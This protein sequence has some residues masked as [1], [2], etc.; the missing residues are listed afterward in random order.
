MLTYSRYANFIGPPRNE[1]QI[2][3][4]F[5][6]PDLQSAL[7]GRTA[8]VAAAFRP[9]RRCE[10]AQRSMQP[11]FHPFRRERLKG[12][13]VNRYSIRINDQ[14]R[15]CFVLGEEGFCEVEIVD[16]HG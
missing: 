9:E 15:I 5:Q 7:P 6:K 3:E 8:R 11:I 16:Y 1:R 10:C 12:D 14:G 2:G 13:R 4:P